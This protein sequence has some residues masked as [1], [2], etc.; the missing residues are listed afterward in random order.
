ATAAPPGDGSGEC[1]DPATLNG[2]V[3][4]EQR[5]IRAPEV[6][7]LAGSPYRGLD[8][9]VTDT[10]SVQIEPG[11]KVCLR[12]LTITG[13]QLLAVGTA[14]KPIRFTGDPTFGLQ[15]VFAGES[16]ASELRHVDAV[17]ISGVLAQFH[18]LLVEDARWQAHQ[19]GDPSRDF[20]CTLFRPGPTSMIQVRRTVFEGFGRLLGNVQGCPAVELRATPGASTTPTAVPSVFE[21]AVRHSFGTGVEVWGGGPGG[22]QLQ[23]CEV[24]GSSGDGIQIRRESGGQ[25]PTPGVET[26]HGCALFGNGG[27]GVNNLQPGA[28]TVDARGNWWGD[29]AG[30]GGPA[31][32]GV[33]AGVDAS[34]PLAAAPV[35]N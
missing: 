21:A 10:A 33:S 7:T 24:S 28:F 5:V 34:A 35:P 25:V 12:S 22:W 4:D 20:H 3:F 1:S 32:D 19:S 16:R 26:L 18:P 27:L 9:H 13:G 8:V 30:A 14:D 15:L 23:G 6:W 17:G 2:T 29:P 11:V 31:G